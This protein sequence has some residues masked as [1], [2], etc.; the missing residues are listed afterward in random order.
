LLSTA[1]SATLCSTTCGSTEM[2]HQITDLGDLERDVLEL[3]WTHGPISADA[4][5]KRLA[6]E[7]KESTVRTVLKRLEE[8]GY[9]RHSTENRTF[10]YSATQSRSSAAARAVKGIVDRFCHGSVEDVL[11]GLVEAE[12]LDRRE[13]ARLAEKI[14]KAKGERKS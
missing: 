10:L 1:T 11:V 6:R 7:L 9:L 2:E 14:A 5:Q 4:V 8:K 12:V 13:L 3:V